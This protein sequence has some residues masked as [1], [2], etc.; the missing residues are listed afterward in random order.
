VRCQGRGKCEDLVDCSA[1]IDQT[2]E[3]THKTR[4][5]QITT[6]SLLELAK[7]LAAPFDISV[8]SLTGNNISVAGPTGAAVQFNILLTETPYEI[9]E[10][11][12]RYAS[13]LVYEGTDGN[14]IL[15]SVGVGGAMASGFD[16][17]V[18]VQTG[19][20]AFTLDERYSLYVPS[21]SSM[22]ANQD[23]GGNNGIMPF[24]FGHDLGV[25][26][27]RPLIVV[28]EQTQYGQYLCL[29]RAVWEANRRW[30]RSQSVHLTCDSWRDR[31]GTLWTPNA[32]ATINLP[33]LK[34]VKKAWI[35]A[36][37][38]FS[39]DEQRGRVADLTLMPKEAFAIEPSA[40][41]LYDW[42]IADALHG[43]ASDRDNPNF[44]PRFGEGAGT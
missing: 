20:A 12:A 14:L 41:Q 11:V 22:D 13:V 18:N 27:F 21:L 42:Q 23:L 28:S 44:N 31:A 33:T 10:R 15:A 40:L 7:Q 8:S 30:G 24:P 36:D 5:M 4:G 25:T 2:F 37:I 17:G 9:I 43:G 1:G 39:R 38:V 32:L 6:G 26:R 29:Q 19:G 3:A 16:E 35:I 34:I